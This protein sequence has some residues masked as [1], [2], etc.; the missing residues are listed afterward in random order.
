MHAEARGPSRDRIRAGVNLATRRDVPS[1]ELEHVLEAGL[2]FLAIVRRQAADPRRILVARRKVLDLPLPAENAV[3]DIAWDIGE[4]RIAEEPII[5]QFPLQSAPAHAAPF[6]VQR[7]IE[8]RAPANRVRD[9]CIE[10]APVGQ[11]SRPS[12]EFAFLERT[13]LLRRHDGFCEAPDMLDDVHSVADRA[14]RVV[15]M[16]EDDES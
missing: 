6:V 1:G 15:G 5:L 12:Q 11:E 4:V 13:Q 7:G 10:L 3:G 2:E 8:V 9:H 16:P 14:G